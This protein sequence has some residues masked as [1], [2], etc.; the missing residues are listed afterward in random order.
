MRSRDGLL[1]A[2]ATAYIPV[3]DSIAGL[4]VPG[5]D[6]ADADTVEAGGDQILTGSGAG[7]VTMTGATNTDF[8]YT[9]TLFHLD[10]IDNLLA[11]DTI[12]FTN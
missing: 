10:R 4:T 7:K 3:A 11:G 5:S 9:T 12:E 2:A 1:K 8:A 6:T